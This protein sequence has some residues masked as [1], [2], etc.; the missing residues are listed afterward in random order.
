MALP[1]N[2]NTF[3]THLFARGLEDERSRAMADGHTCLWPGE[4]R[5]R[6]EAHDR[7]L[8]G[9]QGDT[10]RTHRDNLI[11][12]GLRIKGSGVQYLGNASTALF[13]DRKQR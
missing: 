1:G 5:A 11:C 10:F 8:E 3:L 6:G 2:S 7:D 4:G 13:C 9:G 12:T